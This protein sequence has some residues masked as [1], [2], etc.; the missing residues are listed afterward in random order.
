MH[1]MQEEMIGWMQVN[2]LCTAKFSSSNIFRIYIK[3][4]AGRMPVELAYAA[5]KGG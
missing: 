1:G 4:L 5:D 3:L 2:R